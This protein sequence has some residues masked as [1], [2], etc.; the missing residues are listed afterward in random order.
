MPRTRAAHRAIGLAVMFGLT[1]A[2]MALAQAPQGGGGG[3]R[4]GP[5]GGGG[6]PGGFMGGRNGDPLVLILDKAVQDELKVTEKQRDAIAKWD[7]EVKARRD[8]LRQNM[9]NMRKA[10]NNPNN[11]AM[12]NN[13][14]IPQASNAAGFGDGDFL[15]GGAVAGAQGV[16]PAVEAKIAQAAQRT[17]MF[18]QMK[19]AN[20]QLQQKSEQ[21]LSKILNTKQ[22][23]RLLQI[24]LQQEDLMALAKP[25]IA[26]KLNLNPGQVE[27]VG[28]IMGGMQDSSRQLFQTAFRNFRGG[29]G[30]P[31][32]GGPGGPGGGGPGGPGG[33]GQAGP[34][35]GGPGRGGPGGP[36]GG[37]QGGRGNRPPLTEEQKT[38]ME[39]Q[40]AKM[41]AGMDTIRKA[42]LK[43]L[44]KVLSNKQAGVW[45]KMLGE[46]FDMS[47]LTPQTFGGP[48]GPGGRGGPNGNPNTADNADPAAKAQDAAKDAKSQPKSKQ[49]TSTVRKTGKSA[50]P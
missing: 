9:Q 48:G 24:A 29:P 30:G 2:A 37:G 36:G 45:K 44:G 15:N 41:T 16:D 34:G 47:K 13:V 12:P 42:T 5:G 39:E 43:Q 49:T 14:A 8:E 32:G 33:G 46:P 28:A 11:G 26:T 31:G 17:A 6:G 21:G 3:G 19:A 27:K 38:Q 35:G 18:E 22:K 23:T 1:V 7:E 25:D 50:R 4:G 10:S 40:R 20:D